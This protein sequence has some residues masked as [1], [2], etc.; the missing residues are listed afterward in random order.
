MANSTISNLPNERSIPDYNDYI[1]SD[2][3][4]DEKTYKIKTSN[5]LK[6]LPNNSRINNI[7]HF[8]QTTKPITRGDGSALV[9]GDRWW[10]TDTSDEWFWNGTYWIGR[11]IVSSMMFSG[12]TVSATTG[13]MFFYVDKLTSDIL[14]ANVSASFFVNSG[15]PLSDTDY[16]VLR[17]FT[18]N[19]AGSGM[20]LILYDLII[21]E[22]DFVSGARS[23]GIIKT[24]PYL[25]IV[26][27]SIRPVCFSFR[28]DA[29]NGSP[30]SIGGGSGGIGLS[31]TYRNIL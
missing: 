17:L 28:Y 4:I 29:D 5:L 30:P 26:T 1:L 25:G 6:N 20:T 24:S 8:Y 27:P 11:L 9:V 31:I 22:S 23:G 10:K 12:H 18:T 13:G 16:H 19:S 15:T 3:P 21:R 14:I 7:E 2:S